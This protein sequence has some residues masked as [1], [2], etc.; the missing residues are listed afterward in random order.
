MKSGRSG[1]LRVVGK[2]VLEDWDAAFTAGR[3]NS[4]V[5]GMTAIAP[6]ARTGHNPFVQYFLTRHLPRYICR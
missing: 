4:S 1:G 2:F 3:E 6:L 5:G